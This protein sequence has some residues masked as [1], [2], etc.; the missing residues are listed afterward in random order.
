MFIP[1]QDADGTH[2]V[3]AVRQFD[4]DDADI[5]AHRQQHL[6]EVV[7][8]GL[9]LGIEMQ[10]GQFADPVHQVC[11]PFTK[12][13][14]DF[15][16]GGRGILDDIMQQGCHD[17]LAVHM[18]LG[19]DAGDFQRMMDVGFTAQALLPFMGTGTEFIG[20]ADSGHLPLGEIGS[21][22]FFQCRDGGHTIIVTQGPRTCR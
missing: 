21:Q 9:G 22:Y 2:I 7:C 20:T 15:V 13:P 10:M 12:A 5:V 11:H 8:L 14:P 1:G 17:S 16:L 18:H 19:E 3:Q 4:Q 6:A